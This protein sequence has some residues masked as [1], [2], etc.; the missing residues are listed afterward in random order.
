[1][2]LYIFSSLYIRKGFKG[3]FLLNF[4]LDFLIELDWWI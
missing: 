2:M 4:A 1:M 3:L